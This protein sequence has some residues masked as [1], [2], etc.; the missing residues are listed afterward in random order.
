MLGIEDGN[1]AGLERRIYGKDTQRIDAPP[2][3]P[4]Y[5]S[6]FDHIRHEMTQ[7]VLNA[8]LQGCGRGWATGT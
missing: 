5:G 7:Q 1:R 6:N 8:M 4:S 2:S 3:R